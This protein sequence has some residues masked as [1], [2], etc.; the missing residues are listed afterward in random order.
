MTID[1]IAI[2]VD[3]LEGVR[4]F[5]LK[6]FET[7]CGDRYINP[8][9]KFNSYFITFNGTGCRI[10]IMH[11]G[12]IEAN[13]QN[14]GYVNGLAHFAIRVGDREKVNRMVEVLRNDGFKIVGLPRVS[15]DGYYEAVV[16]DPEGNVVE[17][18]AE[19]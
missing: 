6:Y 16:L 14:K 12:N 18:I 2:W 9:T 15:G 7:S 8:V 17:L 1:H 10:E 19:S 13:T 11:R 3:D 5:Y 4:D